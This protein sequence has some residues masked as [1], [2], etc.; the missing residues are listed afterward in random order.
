[1]GC[2]PPWD[3]WGRPLQ[4]VLPYLGSLL[5]FP[6][7][8]ALWMLL[9]LKPSL[10]LSYQRELVATAGESLHFP[11]KQR[12]QLAWPEKAESCCSRAVDPNIFSSPIV[13]LAL[14]GWGPNSHPRCESGYFFKL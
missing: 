5:H 3:L 12:F 8:S 6:A 9:E 4:Q 2:L 7:D 11:W 10:G 1:M 13:G 14:L